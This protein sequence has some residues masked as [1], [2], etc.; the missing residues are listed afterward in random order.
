[1]TLLDDLVAHWKLDETSGNRVDTHNPWTHLMLDNN[2]VTSTTGK[3][4]TAARFTAANEEWLETAATSGLLDME[5]DI[6][7]T[8]TAW[9]SLRNK[10]TVRVILEANDRT[11]ADPGQTHSADQFQTAYRAATDRFRFQVS[12]TP[13]TFTAIEA[14]SFGAPSTDT[15]YFYC[16]WHDA[17]ADT[18]NIQINNGTIDSTAHSTGINPNNGQTVHMGRQKL[19]PPATDNYAE[20][21]LDEV[22]VWRRVLTAGERTSLYNSGSG[23]AYPFGVPICWNYTAPYRGSSRMYKLSG[24]G[25]FPRYLDVPDNVDKTK[26]IMIDDG[27][28]IDPDEYEV[29]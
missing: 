6:S 10:D 18:I 27:V 3:I 12:G 19:D 24:P 28:L 23:L 20:M 11:L 9:V 21:D 26:G 5:G 13:T 17:D 16:A 14:T 29:S 22:S 4:G 1:M 8:V 15:F 25:A 2:T 7:F